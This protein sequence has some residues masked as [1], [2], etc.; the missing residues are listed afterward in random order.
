[1][2]FESGRN[3]STDVQSISRKG[4]PPPTSSAIHER[5]LVEFGEKNPLRE[6]YL[7]FGLLGEEK[8]KLLLFACAR[9]IL[10]WAWFIFKNETEF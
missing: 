6:Y 9:K 7:R 4:D 2:P 8:K 3:W 5:P 10:I 1:M